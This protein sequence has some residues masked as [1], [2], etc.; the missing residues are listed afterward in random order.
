MT[1]VLLDD[2]VF[3]T[4]ETREQP[5][6]YY[7]RLVLKDENAIEGYMPVICGHG[8]SMWLCAGCAQLIL[9]N[10]GKENT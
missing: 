5:V 6:N 1:Y 3:R 10:Q 4:F 9:E 8:G 7:G 2:S